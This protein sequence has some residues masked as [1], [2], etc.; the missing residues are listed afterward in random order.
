MKDTVKQHLTL[1][2]ERYPALRGIEADIEAAYRCLRD[3]YDAGGKLLVAGNGGSAADAQHIVGELM[4]GFC[5]K[6]PLS[7]EDAARLKAADASMGAELAEKLEQGLF[8][9]SL[10]EHPAL[11]TAYGN[12]RDPVLCF[13]QQ[14]W[15]YGRPGDVFLAISTSGNSRNVLYAAAAARARGLKVIALSGRDGG[16][17]KDH[18]D[19]SVI[20]PAQETFMIQEL[21]LPVYHCLCRMLEDTYYEC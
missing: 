3:A 6:R 5:K 9:L 14:V 20:V 8:A 18:A 4:K 21:H 13:S 17:L 7:R 2:L 19:I 10:T 11:N 15:N 12:D 16:R 1:L